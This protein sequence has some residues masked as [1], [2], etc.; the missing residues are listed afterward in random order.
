MADH[1]VQSLIRTVEMLESLLSDGRAVLVVKGDGDY[2]ASCSPGRHAVEDRRKARYSAAETLEGA[3]E[4][5]T[6]HVRRKVCIRQECPVG[7]RPQPLW[8]FTPDKDA[9]DGRSSACKSCESKRVKSITDRKKAAKRLKE[10]LDAL[11]KQ[12]ENDPPETP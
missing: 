6:D 9:A 11:R 3:I 2:M 4:G 12:V 7:G 1:A 5:L 8:R 10:N